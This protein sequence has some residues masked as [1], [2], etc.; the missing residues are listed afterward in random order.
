[1]YDYEKHNLERI[2]SGLSEC[3]VLLKR[4][5]R[6]PLDKPCKIAAY[7]GG[8]RRTIKGGTGSGEVNSRFFVSVEQ[9]LKDAGFTLTTTKW[10]DDYDV[11]MEKAHDEFI[12]GIKRRAKELHIPAALIG[13]GAVMPEPNYDLP[14]DADGDAA[15]YV[16]SRTSGEGND[17]TA[18]D[19]DFC[20]SKT[21]IRDILALNKKFDKFMLVL[22]VGGPV[23]LTPVEEVGNILL[24]S[25]LGVETGK[26]LADIL[27]DNAYPS[28][29]LATTWSRPEDYPDVGTFAQPDDTRY[30]E[31]IY[32]GY[33]WFDANGKRAMYPFGFGLGY[34]DFVIE[35]GSASVD[36]TTV[37]V[38]ANVKNIG[39]YSGKQT[40]QL[41]VS[42]PQGRLDKPCKQLAAFVKT[43][44]L[45]AGESER[46]SCS[47][48]M[49]EVASY[50]TANARYVLEAGDYVVYC[51][52]SSVNVTPTVVLR[53]DRDVTT[54]QLKNKLGA[55]DFEDWKP[56]IKREAID[57]AVIEIN[58]DDFGTETVS[59]DNE[60]EI[61]N[62]VKGLTNEE[63]CFM[64]IGSFDPKGG[65]A[66]VIGS[67]SK[68]VAGAAGESCGLF[69]D[70]GIPAMVMADGPAGVRITPKYYEDKNGVH[71]IGAAMP[72]TILD[73]MPGIVRWMMS[74]QP[75]IPKGAT[76]K[77]QYATAIP[78]GT[79]IAQSWNV[80]FAKTCGDVVGDELDRF[81]VNLWLAP[82]LNIHR[83]PFCGRNFE[84]YSE[85][86]L[87][88]GEMS[89]AITNGVQAHK[90]CGVTIK[91]YAANNQETNRYFSNSIV[92][93][94][95]MREIYLKGF[96]ICVKKSDPKAI[97]TSY[98]L[99]NGTHASESR[100]LC[101]DVLRSE[102]GFTG[103]CMTDWVAE[104]L[105][106]GAK[107]KY[108]GPDPA[109]VAAAG[110]D[111]YMP[112]GKN[113]YKKMT[114]GLT[115]GRV[116]QEQLRINA[117]RVFN[118]AKQLTE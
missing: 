36:K 79:A 91:H 4:D 95:A 70:K 44:E 29:K 78:I 118:M 2:R 109:L 33:R 65:A 3:T 26:T 49:E 59:Y 14:L 97:M 96:E 81:G 60:Y 105:S 37:T 103:V 45:K 51:G 42:C 23:D 106:S 93:E 15:V 77:E 39:N 5:G 107:S 108:A 83:T 47:F 112:G 99:I 90:G 30:N 25:Q 35:N 89:A 13:M 85:D 61:A 24:L 75:R 40:V 11:I 34:T 1:M 12:K 102:F 22:N 18:T 92:S 88:S 9:G 111:L 46:V 110:G 16:L 31:G 55:P 19:G 54:K 58:A 73:F 53:L 38:S 7:G 56:E 100:D 8:V 94:R 114:E 71:G 17:R 72:A 21:E 32:I 117:T 87:I 64:N 63:L 68:N 43:N 57:C 6:F 84:Y 27:L 98:N 115:A 113:D 28:G 82:A 74:R 62:E 50:D 67:A 80:D 76:V 116:S 48:N 52:D 20:L 104:G 41:Y 69:K 10:L 66:S 86:P 101:E